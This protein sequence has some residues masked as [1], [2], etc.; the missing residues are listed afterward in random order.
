MNQR[1]L[2]LSSDCTDA[3]MLCGMLSPVS[4]SLD[5]V[6]SLAE[7]RARL[8]Q[9]AYGAI[10]TEAQLPDGRWTDVLELTHELGVFPAVIVTERLADD[11][12]W[13][14]VLNLGAYDLLAQ[15]FDTGEVRRILSNACS[16]TSAK[17]A[18]PNPAVKKTI[19]AAS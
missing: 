19:A 7:A 4:V 14:E 15:P 8:P 6:T 12:F 13:A 1:V 16:Q 2:F 5:H 18:S 3:G 9:G 10:L 17:S 11:R